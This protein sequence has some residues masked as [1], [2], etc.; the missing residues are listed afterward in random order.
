MELCEDMTASHQTL[1]FHIQVRWL[2]KGNVLKR[3]LELLS[4]IKI[5]LD[6]NGKHEFLAQINDPRSA[7]FLVY[8]VDIFER[9]NTL[10]L[11]LQGKEKYTFDLSDKLK[12]FQMKIQNLEKKN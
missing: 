10:N 3:V 1:L 12:A 6:Q 8:L 4:E 5:F 11:S 7:V 2:S 9:I